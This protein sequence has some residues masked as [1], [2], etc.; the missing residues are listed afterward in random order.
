M[1]KDT[2]ESIIQ[3]V[4]DAAPGIGD[5]A[6]RTIAQRIHQDLGGT[7]PY[8]AKASAWGKALR[9]GDEIAAGV[10]LVQAFAKIG[11]SQRTGY[12]LI[13]RRVRRLNRAA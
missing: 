6:L 9:L 5:E 11:V 2:V 8:I 13:R 12:R 4:R 10:P 3:M 1:G 7:R